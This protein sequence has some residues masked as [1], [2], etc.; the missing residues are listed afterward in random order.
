MSGSE[1][2]QA[3]DDAAGKA[4]GRRPPTKTPMF[5]ARNSARYERQDLIKAINAAE[6]TQLICYVAGHDT[7]INRD[8]LLGFVDLLH[9]ISD[10]EPVD[11]MLHTCGG[12][13]DACEKLVAA[14]HAKVGESPFRVIVPDMAK[15]AGTLMALGANSVIMSDTS[16][17]GMIDPQYPMADR[18]GN[19]IMHS[20]VAYLEAYEEH[21]A[22]LRRD[23]KDPIALLMLDGFDAKIVRKFQGIR[24]R[25]RTFAEDLLKRQGLPAS[26]ISAELLSSSRWKTHAQPISHADATQLGL[27]IEYVAPDDPRWARYWRLYCLQRIEIAGDSKIFESS[28][29]SQVVEG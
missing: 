3:A 21:A 15:S 2:D 29:V 8:D 6:K 22:A 10:G 14:I 1:E 19:V 28:F 9:N 27:P 26:A 20:V 23:V 25:V 4:A 17:L 16:E 13:V 24:D 7:E 5:T 11:L 12:D 18:Q